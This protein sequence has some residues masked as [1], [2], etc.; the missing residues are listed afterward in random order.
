VAIIAAADRYPLTQSPFSIG[1][2]TLRNRVVRTAHG[3]GYASNGVTD[4]LIAFHV[5]RARGGIAM[6]IAETAAVHPTSPSALPAWTDDIIPGWA[7]LAD[8]VH[9]HGM[10]IFH[11]LW[12]AG[13]QVL[14]VGGGPSW[15]SSAIPEPTA[16]R[17]PIAMTKAM[18]D[19]IVEGFAATAVRARDSGLDGV[20][21]HAGHTYLISQFLSPLTNVRTDEYGGD[22]EN[23]A[24]FAR[25][26][27]AAVR[28]AV[29]PDFPVGIR[30]SASD[31]VA[32]GV[33]PDE[34]TRTAKLLEAD[35]NLDFVDVSMGGYYAMNKIIGAMHEPHGYEL[36]DVTRVTRAVDLPTIVTGRILTLAEVERVLADGDADL[37]SM[38]RATLADPELVTKSLAGREAEVTPCIG[39]N[40]GCVGGRNTGGT[41]AGVV[42]C[43]VN[44]RAGFE[45]LPEPP[46]PAARR[47][48]LVAGAGPAGLQAAWVA[49]SRGHDV[50]VHE[51][52]D[53]A[54]GLVR[55]SRAAPKRD[56]IGVICDHLERELGRLDVPIRF[57][58]HVDAALVAE[59]A[60]DAVIVATGSVPSRD[61]IQRMRPG[62]R[63]AG[64]DL[65]HVVDAV[66]V[67]LHGVGA[68]RR[69][70]VFD[71]MGQYP[72]VGVTE[73]LLEQGLHVTLATSCPSLAPELVKTMQRDPAALRLGAHETFSLVT[74]TSLVAVTAETVTLRGLDD[75]QE[76]VLPADLVVLV[77]SFERRADLADELAAT[78]VET[79]LAGDAVAPLLMQH[80]IASGDRAGVAV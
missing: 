74:R 11:Q 54:G 6:T 39:C 56:E 3:T 46:A 32:G 17:M 79:H 65:P 20:E 55:A 69:A 24:R 13:S 63:P 44:P 5:A 52:G 21:I 28:A 35:G 66:D 76:E 26:V 23:R 40:E 45:Y 12:H 47:R 61:G 49:A 75:E 53:H 8:A 41:A 29:G 36:P 37:V 19:E 64:L 70:V 9:E 72:A 27:T 67:L 62:L 7:R 57:G 58:S 16:G 51:A 68:A 77:T 10:K 59:F 60:P 30:L 33:E 1:S 2:L 80:A 15:S 31:G 22:A 43:T 48:I 50:E 14:P 73:H 18:I 71:D 4:R 34:A 78:G 25:E 38:V 42:G